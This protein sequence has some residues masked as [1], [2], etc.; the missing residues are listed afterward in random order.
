MRKLLV[1]AV[2][3][4]GVAFAG[5]HTDQAWVSGMGTATAPDKGTAK[6]VAVE[7]ATEQVNNMC[8]GGITSTEVTNV[9]TS[10]GDDNNPQYICTATVKHLCEVSGR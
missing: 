3:A 10:S 5:T 7:Q 6:I 9:C 8:V 1:L 4:V 2:I